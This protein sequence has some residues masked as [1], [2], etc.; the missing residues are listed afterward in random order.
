MSF[1]VE[2]CYL[3]ALFSASKKKSAERRR[4]PSKV[5]D[6]FGD[7]GPMHRSPRW[8]CNAFKWCIDSRGICWVNQLSP[9]RSLFGSANTLFAL[10]SFLLGQ[11]CWL[12]RSDNGMKPT[13]ASAGYAEPQAFEFGWTKKKTEKGSKEM[14]SLCLWSDISMLSKAAGYTSSVSLLFESSPLVRIWTECK[15]LIFEWKSYPQMDRW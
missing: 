2:L 7:W 11:I 1:G 10:C 14:S 8:F 15:C 13:K 5:N 9:R 4:F 6:T 12:R 3:K